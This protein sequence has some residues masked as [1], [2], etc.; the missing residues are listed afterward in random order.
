[1]GSGTGDSHGD[2]GVMTGRARGRPRVTEEGM[3]QAISWRVR[4][5]ELW[6]QVDSSIKSSPK[7]TISLTF[8]S[9]RARGSSRRA[10][11]GVVANRFAL[12]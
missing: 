2:I 12:F 11:Q 10:G 4:V 1:M 9:T 6:E 7:L 3:Q 5:H 8:H